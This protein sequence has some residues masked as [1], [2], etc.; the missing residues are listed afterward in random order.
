MSIEFICAIVVG[1]L[2]VGGM[3]GLFVLKF[4]ET[5]QNKIF[6]GAARKK[7]DDAILKL[8]IKLKQKIEIWRSWQM[9]IVLPHARAAVRSAYAV[10]NRLIQNRPM[11]LT[12]VA[13]SKGYYATERVSKYLREVSKGKE[14]G[15][16]GGQESRI[17][18]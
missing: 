12:G 4:I 7:C 18:S 10:T 17:D 9:P 16:V 3:I 2:G 6:F 1:V 5:R 14:R 15:T 8:I 11:R 13:Y